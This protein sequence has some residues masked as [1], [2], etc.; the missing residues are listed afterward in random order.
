MYL[1]LNK[2][3]IENV[4]PY[5]DQLKLKEHDLKV[6]GEINE[7]VGKHVENDRSGT[8]RSVIFH[9]QTKIN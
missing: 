3:I 8:I 9:Y 2:I 6:V 7:L 5:I 1:S 4:L